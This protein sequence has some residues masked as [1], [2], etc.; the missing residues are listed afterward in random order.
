MRK[1]VWLKKDRVEKFNLKRGWF[2]NA[3]R[4]VNANGDDLI[5]PWCATK[6]EALA[7]IKSMGWELN[8]TPEGLLA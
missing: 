7:T 6:K 4:V 2:V 8:M 3:W 5:Q 1:Q